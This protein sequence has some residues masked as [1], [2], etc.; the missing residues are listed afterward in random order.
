MIYCWHAPLS[1]G[2]KKTVLGNHTTK[3]NF[4]IE[5][6]YGLYQTF[7]QRSGLRSTIQ[8][9]QIVMEFF[10]SPDHVTAED[11]WARVRNTYPSI[12]LTTVYR[13]LKLLQDAGL[14]FERRFDRNKSVFE[15]V[16][17][18][19]HHDHLVCIDCGAVVEFENAEIERL[20]E[21]VAKEHGF[22]LKSHRMELLGICPKCQD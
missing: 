12:G 11:L 13:T 14:A 3:D 2:I 16:A 21:Q 1:S 7:A 22:V 5:E 8:R 17:P 9:D 4:Q 10:R 19:S 6:A 15:F 18:G 20:Q